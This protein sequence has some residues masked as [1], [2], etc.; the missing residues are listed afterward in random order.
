MSLRYR[1]RSGLSYG[2]RTPHSASDEDANGV[3]SEE[4]AGVG[5]DT[6]DGGSNGPVDHLAPDARKTVLIG[7]LITYLRPTKVRVLNSGSR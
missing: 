5:I 6:Q 1:A 7:P 3:R 4:I 2:L